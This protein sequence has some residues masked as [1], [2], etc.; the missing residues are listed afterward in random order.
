VPHTPAEKLFTT[1]YVLVGIG[2]LA[3]FVNIMIKNAVTRRQ[4]RYANKTRARDKTKTGA[5]NDK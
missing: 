4:I 5:S 1:G 2:I 3:F